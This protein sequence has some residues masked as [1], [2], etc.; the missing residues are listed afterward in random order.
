MLGYWRCL[1]NH[2]GAP[3]T[4][5]S[6]TFSLSL[7]L[8]RRGTSGTTISGLHA[9]WILIE[10]QRIKLLKIRLSLLVVFLFLL[11]LDASSSRLPP[12]ISGSSHLVARYFLSPF[13]TS[14]I[15]S[16]LT[17]RTEG[18]FEENYARTKGEGRMRKNLF[19]N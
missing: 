1:V 16:I 3:P 13:F 6:H 11:L 8:S 14:R 5:F 7:F 9:G 2:R 4:P 19:A 15:L 12:R 17:I 18:T 10:A